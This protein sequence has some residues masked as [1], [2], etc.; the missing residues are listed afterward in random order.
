[1]PKMLF[2]LQWC[3]QASTAAS[4]EENKS[5]LRLKSEAVWLA[6]PEAENAVQ[7][8][9]EGSAADDVKTGKEENMMRW[10]R[11]IYSTGTTALLVSYGLS[12]CSWWQRRKPD[13]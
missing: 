2:L 10:R 4:S 5:D 6:E 8:R 1:M 3:K 11:N 9:N 12:E 7:N 13:F